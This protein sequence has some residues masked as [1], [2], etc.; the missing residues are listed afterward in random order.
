MLTLSKGK[1]F[2]NLEITSKPGLKR[3]NHFK[4]MHTH[5]LTKLSDWLK[6]VLGTI[7]SISQLI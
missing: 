5:K 3:L 2:T 7:N 6:L 4:M 1:S